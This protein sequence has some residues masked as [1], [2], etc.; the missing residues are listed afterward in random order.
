MH[1]LG[2]ETFAILDIVVMPWGDR[3]AGS[4]TAAALL[5]DLRDPNLFTPFISP[6]ILARITVNPQLGCWEITPKSAQPA[7]T[8]YYG[9]VVS[10]P[11]GVPKTQAHRYMWERLV[12]EI[13]A[14]LVID[15]LCCNVTCCLPLHLE[16][17][18]HQ[19]NILRAYQR[20]LHTR[21]ITLF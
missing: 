19:Q 21:Q 13:P 17:V 3:L 12:G 6:Q 9:S 20:V 10:T 5:A 2:N 7:T 14:D 18:T 1:I 4:Q 8:R 15:H 11:E 16:P